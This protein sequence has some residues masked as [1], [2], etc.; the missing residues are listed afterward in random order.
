MP[1]EVKI[2]YDKSDLRGITRAFKAMD[3]EAVQAAKKESSA[4][5]EFA[6]DK[7]KQTAATRQVSGTAARRIADGVVISK[8]SK[9]GEFS[10]GFAR[11]KFSGGGSTLD[12]LYGMEFGSNRFKQFPNRTPNRGRGNSG[13]FIYPTLR[14]IQPELI[15]KWETAF[16]RILKEWD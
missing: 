7:I 12:L 6:A 16:D 4:L 5:A 11:Q 15:Q 3:D 8:S 13:Y 9:I 14:Q 2:A 1:D 10:Y